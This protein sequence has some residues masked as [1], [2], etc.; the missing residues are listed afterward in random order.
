MVAKE[1]LLDTSSRLIDKGGEFSPAQFAATGATEKITEGVYFIPIFSNAIVV[2][3]ADSLVMVDT[4]PWVAERQVFDRVREI[5]QKPV[6]KAIFTHGHID[7]VFGVRPFDESQSSPPVV[8]AHENL[9]RRFDRYKLT[10]GYNQ[11]INRRQFGFSNLKWPEDFRYPDITYSTEY[12]FDA[13]GTEFSAFHAK[14]E[15][16]DHTWV[17]IPDKKV[18]CTGD[19][20][21]WCSPN[22]GNPQK[23]QR[24]PIEWA[25]A[26]RR[27]LDYEAE[28]LLPGH[29]LPVAGARRIRVILSDTAALL[30]DI[31]EQVVNFMNQGRTLDEILTG[32]KYPEDLLSKPYLR[33]IYDDPEFIVRNIWRLYGGWYDGNPAN[34]KPPPF[35]DLAAEI[36][37]LAG[38]S[39]AL[40]RR[41]EEL[42][43]SGR[44]RLAAALVELA[45]ASGGGS[46]V[47]RIRAEV[48]ES[49]ADEEPSLMAKNIYRAAALQ[50]RRR[51]ESAGQDPD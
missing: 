15:T 45:D 36:A 10:A 38:G 47:Q 51:N 7:H 18:L 35:S 14:G 21:I 29:G 19:L 25:R 11:A 27:M 48:Y 34:L 8:I 42:R 28:Y 40:A 2:E 24:Y 50:S 17:W 44:L 46:E 31:H 30:E 6:S 39:E 13:G 5:S 22:A 49:L 3:T 26:L 23:V 9:P 37:G 1:T 12:S 32:V 4:G 33:P 41:A 20:I 43:S 16:D